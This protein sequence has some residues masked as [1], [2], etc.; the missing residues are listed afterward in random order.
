MKII[1][2]IIIILFVNACIYI[3]VRIFWKAAS[4]LVE[5][6]A[7]VSM[8]DKLCC[9]KRE[10][11]RERNQSLLVCTRVITSKGNPFMHE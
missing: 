1:I 6:R 7:D 2:I 4:T 9:S 5:S 10:R 3:P 11:E 8:K